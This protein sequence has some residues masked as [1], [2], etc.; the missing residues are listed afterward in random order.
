[1]KDKMQIF[2]KAEFGKLRTVEINGE[3]YFV[4]S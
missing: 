1:M 3:I 2:E 4:G